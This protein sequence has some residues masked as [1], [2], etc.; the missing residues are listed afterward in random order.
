MRAITNCMPTNVFLYWF[1]TGRRTLARHSCGLSTAAPTAAA[2]AATTSSLSAGVVRCR[3][4]KH[5]G[6]PHRTT[7]RPESRSHGFAPFF[8]E[9][10]GVVAPDRGNAAAKG[11]L[12]ASVGGVNVKRASA[13]SAARFQ[14][15][16]WARN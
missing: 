1:K 3:P 10:R 12:L 2:A 15:E 8:A 14:A 5:E 6:E 16:N 13:G 11:I 9:A 7:S 4:D